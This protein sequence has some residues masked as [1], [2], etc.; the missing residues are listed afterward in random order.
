M[1]WGKWVYVMWWLVLEGWWL[2]SWFNKLFFGCFLG[3]L[4]GNN[5]EFGKGEGDFWMDDF[6]IGEGEW[7]LGERFCFWYFGEGFLCFLYFDDLYC[8][9]D[10]DLY[11]WGDGFLF[12]EIW[13][14]LFVVFEC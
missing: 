12:L 13:I 2:F 1:K 14:F 7:V 3:F 4:F 6:W 11:L 8:L 5:W 9:G 10:L